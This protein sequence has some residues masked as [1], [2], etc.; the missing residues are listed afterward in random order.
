MVQA[1]SKAGETCRQPDKKTRRGKR[2]Y[3][4]SRL[5]HGRMETITMQRAGQ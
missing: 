2:I 4:V 3:S 5:M 1:L